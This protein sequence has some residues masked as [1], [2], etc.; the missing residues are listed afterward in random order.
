[1]ETSTGVMLP[2]IKT[3]CEW[4][5]TNESTLFCGK[6]E[7]HQ[8]CEKCSTLLHSKQKLKSHTTINMKENFN[9][10]FFLCNTH[11]QE[12]LFYC[13]K[14]Q[15]FICTTCCS[16]LLGGKHFKHRIKLIDDWMMEFYEILFFKKK[17]YESEIESK[18]EKKLDLLNQLKIIEIQI[19]ELENKMSKCSIEVENHG[20][21]MNLGLPP[22][23][24]E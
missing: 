3:P 9:I 18:M 7:T 6:C 15:I 13:I 21:M 1:M 8:L 22:Q 19:N 4:C 10:D 11:Q 14:C 5:E 20:E 12:K 23:K 16:E 24:R 2:T 17:E